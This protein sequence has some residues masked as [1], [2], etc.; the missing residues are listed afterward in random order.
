MVH[1][2]GFGACLRQALA[3]F[4]QHL[5]PSEVTVRVGKQ[6]GRMKSGMGSL[7]AGW[8]RGLAVMG[9]GALLLGSAGCVSHEAE[10]A[11]LRDELARQRAELDRLRGE[12]NDGL[13]LALCNP[14]LRQL[15]E[16]VQRECTASA[17]RRVLG[18]PGWG[19]A[20]PADPTRRDLG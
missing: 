10:L 1:Q 16:D 6:G 13:T 19:S 14:E 18:R 15:L 11:N 4:P 8:R 20:R 5:I 17:P 7:M 3:N 2:T 12:M 9:L